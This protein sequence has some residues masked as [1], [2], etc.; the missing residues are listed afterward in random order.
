MSQPLYLT[1]ADVGR[2]VTVKDAM[3]AGEFRELVAAGKLAWTDVRELGELVAGKA[4]GRHAP[5]TSWPG[6]SR[7]SRSGR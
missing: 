5:S 2:L 3:E 1:E 6:L 4:K 7:P